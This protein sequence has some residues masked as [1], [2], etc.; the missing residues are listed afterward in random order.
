MRAVLCLVLTNT[1]K[2]TDGSETE[3]GA[4]SVPVDKSLVT[5]PKIEIISG[6][7]IPGRRFAR[8]TGHA[9]GAGFI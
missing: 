9:P 8:R 5:T 2:R 4:V 3:S 7:S 6:K 1:V